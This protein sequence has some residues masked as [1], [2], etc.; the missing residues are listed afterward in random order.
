[1]R[2]RQRLEEACYRH[3]A[4]AQDCDAVEAA[5]PPDSADPDCFSE[6]RAV[7]PRPR[8]LRAARSATAA[9][10]PAWPGLH[11]PHRPGP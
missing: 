7:R 9:A 2:R 6:A 8:P 4:L 1:M 3:R 11:L 10:R 5:G